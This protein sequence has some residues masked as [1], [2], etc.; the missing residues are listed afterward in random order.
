MAQKS[1]S[2]LISRYEKALESGKSI[3]LDADDFSDLADYFDGHED[4]DAAREVVE[5]GLKIHPNNTSLLIKRAKFLAFDGDYAEA[6]AILSNFAEYDLDVHLLKIECFL[7]LSLIAESYQLTK[8]VLETEDS[9][10]ENVLAELGFLYVDADY[11]DESILY[12]LKSLDYNAENIDV[13]SDLAYA[14]EMVGNYDKAIEYSNKILDLNSYSFET[15]VNI[16]KL[17]SLKDEYENAIDAFDFALTISDGDENILKLKAHCLSLSGRPYEAIEIFVDLLKSDAE[18]KSLYLLIA[19]CYEWLEL[20]DEALDYLNLSEKVN[21]VS[22][23]L[24]SRIIHVLLLKGDIMQAEMLALNGLLANEDSVELSMIM[25]E[26][27][28]KKE[29]FALAENYLMKVFPA[30]KDNFQ[31]LDMLAIVNIKKEDYA[32]GIDF[33]ELLLDLDPYN[34]SIKHRLALLYFE[35][36]DKDNFN[37][38]LE[39]FTDKELFQLFKFIYTPASDEAFDREHLLF[40]LNEARERRALFKNLKY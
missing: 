23:E 31:L 4:V 33:T 21:G 5:S 16:G 34:L 11:F 18:D 38:V 40:L 7:Q 3:Y 27:K 8:E 9:D 10:L 30:N 29:Q 14:Y 39:Q 25:A 26:I 28:L 17:Y 32:K 2:D 36:A 19:E 35:T 37:A 15:W 20:Y 6:L 1:I 12:F 22:F 13:L 24:L